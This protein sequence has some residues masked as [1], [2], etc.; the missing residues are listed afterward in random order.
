MADDEPPTK[1]ARKELFSEDKE[2]TSSDAQDSKTKKYSRPGNFGCKKFFSFYNKL[3]QREL[4]KTLFTES[5]ALLSKLEVSLSRYNDKENKVNIGHGAV[6]NLEFSPDNQ[7]LVAACENKDILLYD[8]C[9]QRKVKVIQ[10]AHGDG[11]NCVTFLDT[12]TF[13]TCSDDKT[14]ALWDVRN[15]SS[16]V[17]TLKGHTSWV[18]SINYHKPTGQLLSSAFDDTV[19]IWDINEFS[20][21]KLIKSRKVLNVPYL[22]RSK[23]STSADGVSKLIVATTTGVLF[24]IHNLKLNSLRTDTHEELQNLSS[25]FSNLDPKNTYHPRNNSRTHNRIEFIQ[26]FPSTSKPWCIASIQTHPLQD[27]ILSR[28][29]TLDTGSEWSAVHSLCSKG[30]YNNFFYFV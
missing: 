27:S 11:V 12:R 18:K 25:I 26:E 19:R 4:G 24:V 10:K 30:N 21:S 13:A 5:S 8:P 7:Y 3:K 2:I 14:I 29:T 22:T 23:L 6:F 17:F 28:Y 1:K 16:N 9:N 15:T 20:K